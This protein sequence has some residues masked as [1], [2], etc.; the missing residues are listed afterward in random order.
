MVT[1]GLPFF[2]NESSL[3]DT[4]RS[5][6]AQTYQ[7]W[8]LILVDDGSSD[9]SLELARTIRDE[10][11]R[12]FSDGENKGLARRLN[13]IADYARG[14]LMLRLDAD[15]L[16]HPTRAARIVEYFRTNPNA[17]AVFSGAYVIDESGEVTG[18][19][20]VVERHTVQ[21]VLRKFFAC[22]PTL[23][24]TTRWARA[25]PYPARTKRAEDLDLWCKCFPT[26]RFE[27]ITD[28]LYY[29]RI[30]SDYSLRKYAA[31]ANDHCRVIL[32][33]GPDMLGLPSTCY[34]LARA[35][36]KTLIHGAARLVGLNALSARRS[37]APV[38]SRVREDEHHIIADMLAL[39]LPS[40]A[41][42]GV[43]CAF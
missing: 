20:P 23:A 28:P 5:V 27:Y 40:A 3:L 30:Q 37:V 35:Q 16:M 41:T 14:D 11:V 9:R 13:E 39:Q 19:Q 38:T 10:R 15:D 36:L 25:N 22:H 4:I 33:Y 31:T 17:D 7:D 34:L 43:P 1:I 26:T 18:F 42:T 24:G 2:N 8:E 32:S 6:F 29:C 21:E 12:L